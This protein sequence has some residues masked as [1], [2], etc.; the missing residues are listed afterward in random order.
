MEII[1][2]P[3]TNPFLFYSGKICGYICWIVL[4]LAIFKIDL[5]PSYSFPF[6][7]IL[8]Y[9]LLILGLCLGVLSAF[10]LGNSTRLGLPDTVTEFKKSGLYK[11]SRNPMYL[12]FNL[13]TIA[14]ILFTL[15]PILFINGLYS[16]FVYHFI[17]KGEER[18]L[19]KRFGN[20]YLNYKKTVR[21][22]I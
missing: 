20:D 8:A 22:Y 17:I 19:E 3:S 7:K 12:G 9:G 2:K 6:S 13:I 11:I 14:S 1:G 16:I 5:L 4:I 10:N 21:R 15:S 18:F